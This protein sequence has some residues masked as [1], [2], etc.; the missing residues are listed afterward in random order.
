[1]FVTSAMRRM[2]RKAASTMPTSMATV[3]ST[4]TVS[5]NVV[6]RTATSLLG[7]RNSAM[8]VRHSLMWNATTTRIAASVASGIRPAQRPKKSV[9]N[10]SVIACTIPAIGVRPPFFT[11]VAVRAIA[12]V[13]GIPPNNGEAILAMPCATSSM[14]ERWRPPI[15]PSATTAD[16]GD[17]DHERPR[18]DRIEGVNIGVPLRQERRWDGR[19]LETE[20]VTDLT[21]EDDQRDAAGEADRHRIGNELD[22]TAEPQ[23][24]EG[25]EDEASH[26][27]GHDQPIDAV[28][29]H[30]P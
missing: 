27:R 4:S 8:N 5:R 9:I 29:E 19:H 15:M 23:Q 18:I 22:R 10:S 28:L 26:E 1:M 20:Q 25:D 2:N 6:S 24:A 21:R 30:Y 3:K 16:R 7:A 13:A 12:P 14:L 17:R 11:F